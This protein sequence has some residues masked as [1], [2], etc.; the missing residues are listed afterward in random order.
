MQTCIFL[1]LILIVLALSGI[2]YCLA[3][4]VVAV[5]AM[6]EQNGSRRDIHDEQIADIQRD[7]A[8]KAQKRRTK[9]MMEG[10]HVSNG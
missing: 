9:R 4:I 8:D 2:I 5:E 10:S 6:A 7:L 1:A 3:R